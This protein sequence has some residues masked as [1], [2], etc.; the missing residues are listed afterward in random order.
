[1][2][3]FFA[4]Y[5]KLVPLNLDEPKFDVKTFSP[6]LVQPVFVD[7]LK[8]SI[9]SIL[10]SRPDPMVSFLYVILDK[11]LALISAFINTGTVL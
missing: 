1:M 3:A 7:E 4:L 9:R 10:K 11:F 5:D 6:T 2:S 8:Q